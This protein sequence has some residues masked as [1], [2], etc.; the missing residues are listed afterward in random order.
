MIAGL[1]SL[2]LL[3]EPSAVSFPTLKL[4]WIR[5]IGE[6]DFDAYSMCAEFG[7]RWIFKV[8]SLDVYTC[9]DVR[10]GKTLWTVGGWH[11]SDVFEGGSKGGD[12]WWTLRPKPRS[13]DTYLVS[14]DVDTGKARFRAENVYSHPIV[15]NHELVCLRSFDRDTQ[16]I[17]DTFRDYRDGRVLGEIRGGRIIG[18]ELAGR[19]EKL[20]H[21]F[22]GSE[23][24]PYT[25]GPGFKEVRLQ[26]Y[27]ARYPSI[28]RQI[29]PGFLLV[30]YEQEDLNGAQVVHP[31]IDAL[32][33][34]EPGEEPEFVWIRNTW[35]YHFQGYWQSTMRLWA[36]AGKDIVF[37]DLNSDKSGYALDG[38][39][40]GVPVGNSDFL[41]CQSTKSQDWSLFW[42]SKD[43]KK[44]PP[45]PIKG[46][47]KLG[48]NGMMVWSWPEGKETLAFYSIS[49]R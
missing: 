21:E 17:F 18:D 4:E 42:L 26:T 47:P 3:G 25:L 7:S 33:R 1:L 46:I 27:E 8:G 11:N 43:L 24:N 9:I 5:E 19:I 37:Y 41:L 31:Y 38:R 10:T 16:E 13:S 49:E 36:Q 34:W 22:V 20:D 28:Y 39:A 23:R 2:A 29:A 6:W 44:S 15:I 30:S 48:D 14:V 32:Y 12:V 45:L 40:I 35:W